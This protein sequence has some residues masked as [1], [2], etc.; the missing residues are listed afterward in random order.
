MVS[1]NLLNTS[2]N[3]SSSLFSNTAL[4]DLGISSDLSRLDALSKSIG[5]PSSLNAE[6]T[7]SQT[8]NFQNDDSP[9]AGDG[10]GTLF[11]DTGKDII[12]AGETASNIFAG[13]GNKTITGSPGD[14]TIYA[15]AG[16]D[17]IN[18]GEGNNTVFSGKG[19]N[20]VITAS[21]NDFVTAG[22][23]NNKQVLHR[24]WR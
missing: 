8:I 19:N 6:R 13:E 11:A 1:D 16:N 7:A 24:S 3:T 18:A 23:A 20:R 12:N 15:Q 22:S 9:I 4:A 21:G 17:I 5:S 2:S 10:S 14:D